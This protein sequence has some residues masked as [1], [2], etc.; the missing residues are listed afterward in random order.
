MRRGDKVFVKTYQCNG[1]GTGDFIL[2]PA[3]ISIDCKKTDDVVW[4]KFLDEKFRKDGRSMHS[5]QIL[6]KKIVR[7]VA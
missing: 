3:E 1:D 2:R 4:V 6:A 7:G 5:E